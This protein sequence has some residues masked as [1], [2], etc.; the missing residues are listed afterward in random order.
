M[1]SFQKIYTFI[2]FVPLLLLSCDSSIEETEGTPLEAV[3]IRYLTPDEVMDKAQK[4]AFKY[5]W[6]YANEDNFL[7]LERVH[8]DNTGYDSNLIAIGGSGFGLMN[9]LVGVQR[10]IITRAEAVT[11]LQTALTW[12]QNADRFHGA[13]GHWYYGD[14]GHVREIFSG[15]NGADLV[16]TSFLCEGLICVR[17]FFKNGTATEQALATKADTLWKG[18][19]WNWFTNGGN[20]LIWHWSPTLGFTAFNNHIS[21][22]NEA[23]ITYVLAGSSPT[24]AI[25]QQVYNQGWARNGGIANGATKY[26]LPVVLDHAGAGGSVGPM[27]YS[28]YS[29]MGIDPR[30]L[31]DSYV[32]YGTATTNHA[33]IQH[34]YSVANPNHWGGYSDE[35]WGLTAS[36][37]RNPDGTTGYAAH[38]IENDKGVIAPTAAFSN[39]AY[40]PTESL[41]FMKYCYE[42]NYDNIIGACGP[43]DAFSLHYNWYSKRYLAI[44]QGTIAP[45]IENYRT[46]LLWNL[47]MNAP[48]VRQGMINLGFHSTQHGF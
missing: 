35:V 41:K 46:G 44:D 19:E 34:A 38:S 47:F 21:G 23:F 31:T 20:D 48:D 43:Y 7:A 16:E 3:P 2:L 45:M 33:K 8:F 15:D 25:S 11:R 9:I 10:G 5:F 27:F 28:H 4:D 40:T 17:E 29:F 24:H 6:N 32:N 18:V 12:L 36:E 14:S 1:N 37:S 22:Y 13:W 30:G 39:I 26:G 42:K